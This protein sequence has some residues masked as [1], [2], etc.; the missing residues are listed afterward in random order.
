MVL[1]DL[2]TECNIVL[3]QRCVGSRVDVARRPAEPV[4]GADA[5]DRAAVGPE[6]RVGDHQ[7]VGDAEQ[8][9]PGRLVGV[10]WSP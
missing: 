5:L 1:G 2:S 6:W 9:P 4:P 3:S 10:S 7:V 8:I